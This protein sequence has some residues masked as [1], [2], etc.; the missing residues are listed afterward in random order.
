MS[1]PATV[2]PVVVVPVVAAMPIAVTAIAAMVITIVPALE[3]AVALEA[4]MIVAPATVKALVTLMPAE[5]PDHRA[6]SMRAAMHRPYVGVVVTQRVTHYRADRERQSTVVGIGTGHHWQGQ[7]R[8]QR[9]GAEQE[10]GYF[11]HV[12]LRIAFRHAQISAV[13]MNSH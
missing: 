7:G 6:V 4:P 1:A 5:G 2:A 8:H 13:G 9:A 10:G 12:C 11:V 3:A